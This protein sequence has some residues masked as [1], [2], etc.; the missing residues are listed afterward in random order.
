M[1]ITRLSEI[2][3][4]SLS[5][6]RGLTDCCCNLEAKVSFTYQCSQQNGNNVDCYEDRKKRMRARVDSNN[7]LKQY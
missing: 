1:Y 5:P 2:I 4:T 6:V 7:N 3:L